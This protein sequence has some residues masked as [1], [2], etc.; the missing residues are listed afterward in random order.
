MTF[1]K[2]QSVYFIYLGKIVYAEIREIID[3]NT[4]KLEDIRHAD[5]HSENLLATHLMLERPTS[6]LFNSYKEAKA[7]LD[8]K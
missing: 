1:K 8:R 2:N 7:A 5:G 6:I 4:V 3:D